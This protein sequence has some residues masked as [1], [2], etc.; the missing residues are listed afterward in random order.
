M[1]NQPNQLF[2]AMR[3]WIHFALI[4][5]LTA[6][7][8][9]W[10]Q[11]SIHQ[12]YTDAEGLISNTIYDI[13]Q[14][15]TGFIWIA[16]DNGL[17]RFD[18]NRFLH[19]PIVGNK[20][21]SV[22]NI[23]FTNDG[24][25]WVQN[26]N[27]QFFKTIGAKLVVQPQLAHASNFNLAHDFDGSKIA[28]LAQNKV[29]VYSIS[30]RKLRSIDLPKMD[31]LPANSST[32]TAF[33]LTNIVH[34]Q[35][36]ELSSNG[37][38]RTSSINLPLTSVYYHRLIAKNEDYLIGKVAN[39]LMELRSGRVYD[40]SKWMN[41][42][43]VQN[44]SLLGDQYVAILTTNGVVLFDVKYKT[45]SKIFEQHSCSKIIQDR[46]GNWWL[47]TLGDGLIFIPN[48]SAK[49]FLKGNEISS[50]F[51]QGKYMYL[52]TKTN[53]IY[54]FD[55]GSRQLE[56]I[57]Q[58]QENHEVKS[59]YYQP[60]SDELMFCSVIFEHYKKGKLVQK[61]PISVNKIVPL[62]D[63]H[64]V[65]CESGN[66]SIYP[67]QP[68][69]PLMD[70]GRPGSTIVH[71][72]LALFSGNRRFFNAVFN[73][74]QLVAHASDGLWLIEKGT[75]KRLK[76]GKSA[77]IKSISQS[78]IGIIITTTDQGVFRF[79]NN[80][81]VEEK[82]L[83]GL[84]KNQQ[85]YETKF[86]EGCFYVLTYEGTVVA[87][88]KGKLIQESM[89]TDG[90]PNVDVLDFE[91]IQRVIHATTT[92]GLQLIPLPSPNAK[93]VRSEIVVNA[94]F[95]NGEQR[96][97]TTGMMLPTDENSLRFQLS[98]INFK[99]LGLNE[100]YYSVNGKKWLP[101]DDNK[102]YLNELAPGKYTVRLYATTARD[103]SKS[104][105]VSLQ[106]EI[107]LPYYQQWWFRV[108]V[109]LV[110]L[111]IGFLIFKW[112]LKQVQR[113]N[114]ILQEKLSL[115]KQ[116][117]ASS[118]AAIKSQMNPHFLFNALN[119]I[120]SFIY[121]NEKEAA[122]SYLV[123]F[124]ELTRKILEMSNQPYVSLSE[125]IEALRLYLKLEKMRFEDDFEFDIDTSML[126]HEAHQIPSMLI[127][128]YVENAIKHGLL[129]KKG[130][131]RLA[132]R[133][134]SHEATIEVVVEDNGIGIEASKKI[135]S[136]RMN[137]HQSFA[138]DANQKR[139]E[140]LNQL[141]D[142]KIGVQ[143]MERLNEAGNVVGTTVHLSIPIQR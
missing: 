6:V 84:L 107:M 18:G 90:Y 14:D 88:R 73:G 143:L 13:R 112:R 139:F 9:S 135:N 78:E 77:D 98:V 130:E 24:A 49:V 122:S 142:G 50:Y 1:L 99:A 125:E 22:S 28:Y 87:D 117:H 141:S 51:R 91:V 115:E 129:H 43:F 44:A 42:S 59:V 101:V 3:C 104:K 103:A 34:Q 116:L 30:D 138:T 48:P 16:T 113:K 92:N 111:S 140:L 61:L 40:F 37:S 136:N 19:F 11:E 20:A 23:L 110:L 62:D 58:N 95:V 71:H 86:V 94:F 17:V 118:L 60:L 83:N 33:H 45:F 12:T 85:L 137:K 120:Q 79:V 54:R 53:A 127:Q 56:L 27:G 102:L 32:K 66:L 96:T 121:T 47:G 63:K 7:Q 41:N 4:F 80:R 74:N 106:F 57:K 72:R 93:H 97:F 133:F 124:S 46:E 123:D 89:R 31:W 15:A 25:T 76:V 55:S 67:I 75:I 5:F 26:F 132:I 38:F 119:T 114:A 2:L 70:W 8:I 131:K 105:I 108:L 36:L 29:N 134:V 69:D 128:P 10:G 21:S 109:A 100:V 65:L 35:S 52:G 82:A 39:Q 68:N 81:I 126:V 64:V